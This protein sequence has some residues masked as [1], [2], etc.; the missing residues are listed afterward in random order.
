[1][2]Q[3]NEKKIL[4]ESQE[5]MDS[6]SFDLSDDLL[7]AIA[8]GRKVGIDDNPCWDTYLNRGRKV[9]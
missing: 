4:D 2:S 6:D 1:M 5:L 3:L 9:C 7:D 8:G